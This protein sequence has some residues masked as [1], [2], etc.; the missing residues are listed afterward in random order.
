MGGFRAL[1][2]SMTLVNIDERSAGE[3]REFS[4]VEITRVRDG[5]NPPRSSV[6]DSRGVENIFEHR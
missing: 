4:S 6:M 2:T 3:F 5:R 1:P